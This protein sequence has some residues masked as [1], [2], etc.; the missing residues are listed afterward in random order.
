MVS[1]LAL[2]LPS[3][4]IMIAR[5]VLRFARRPSKKVLGVRRT[6][7]RDLRQQPD[8]PK[9]LGLTRVLSWRAVDIQ[10]WLEQQSVKAG[11]PPAQQQQ[12]G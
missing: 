4:K 7:L 5:S 11:N 10:R 6:A 1:W 9:P 2:A 3:A 8:F 12:Q